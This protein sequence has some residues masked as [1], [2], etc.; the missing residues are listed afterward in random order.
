MPEIHSGEKQ[1]NKPESREDESKLEAELLEEE[2]ASSAPLPDL[3]AT[4]GIELEA[5]VCEHCDWSYLFPLG[6]TPERCLHCFETDLNPL[7]AQVSHL[8]HHAPPELVLPFTVSEAALAQSI[9]AFAQGIPYPPHDLK[10]DTLRTRLETLYLP[11]WLVD[12]Q[13]TATWQAEVGFNYEVVSHQAQYEQSR[14]TWRSQEVIETRVR[15]EPRLGRLDRTYHN[16]PAPA[17]EE[18][19]QIESKLGRYDLDPAQPYHPE[20]VTGATVRLPGRST[21]DAWSEADPAFQSAAVEECRRAT[22]ADHIRDYRW[23]PSFHSKHWTLLLLPAYVT[24]YLD[25]E[26]KPQPLLI[27]GQSG[28]VSGVRRA[29][30]QRAQRTMW[31][32][33][34]I[35]VALFLVSLLVTVASVLAPVLLVIGLLGLITSLFVGLVSLVPI[36]IAWQFNRSEAQKG[37]L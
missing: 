6:A 16:I 31:I 14:S 26:Q 2:T 34:S 37:S 1:T 19:S 3:T 33:I 13:V 10:P 36:V 24:Y 18:S 20:T 9:R 11:K 25:D 22:S 29:S 12:S 30:L 21:A 7:T 28:R 8:P 4:W 5:A 17:L 35:A 23:E 15:W 32:I 27:H